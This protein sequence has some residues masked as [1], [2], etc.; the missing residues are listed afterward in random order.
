MTDDPALLADLIEERAALI[1][2]GEGCSRARAEDMA[3]RSHWFTS[4]ADWMKRGAR[5]AA[6]NKQTTT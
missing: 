5:M 4:W 3:A 6:E 1:E 2:C